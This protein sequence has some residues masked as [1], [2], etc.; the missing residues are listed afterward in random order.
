METASSWGELGTGTPTPAD[1]S[2]LPALCSAPQGLRN[3]GVRRGG[4]L[5]QGIRGVGV[6]GWRST[7]GWTKLGDSR[8]PFALQLPTGN[9][10]K[11][12]PRGSQSPEKYRGVLAEGV[13]INR[14]PDSLLREFLSLGF[15]RKGTHCPFMKCPHNSQTAPAD[16][17]IVEGVG[18]ILI[19]ACLLSLA[20]PFMLRR[21]VDPHFSG[22]N[23]TGNAFQAIFF[24]SRTSSLYSRIF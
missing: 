14:F 11:A 19:K 9:V 20:A 10:G 4:L 8:Q 24:P 12:L 18:E 23:E 2:L 21:G 15:S 6:W 7:R 3:D 1:K 5:C 22:H 16:I 17:P 13:I